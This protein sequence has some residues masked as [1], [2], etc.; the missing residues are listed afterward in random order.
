VCPWPS[1]RGDA[2]RRYT[3][4]SVHPSPPLSTLGVWSFVVKAEGGLQ[5]N[6]WIV[7]AAWH[8]RNKQLTSRYPSI[9]CHKTKV[10]SALSRHSSFSSLSAHANTAHTHAMHAIALVKPTKSAYVAN[11]SPWRISGR[12][13]VE[14]TFSESPKIVEN[15]S[16]LR[17]DSS[18]HPTENSSELM[19]KRKA[20][21]RL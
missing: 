21:M 8:K 7:S 13:S 12:T 6:E 5:A 4:S 17:T 3:T 15:C 18:Q 9:F 20:W 19:S 10:P 11:S 2:L 1:R 16:R 14:G